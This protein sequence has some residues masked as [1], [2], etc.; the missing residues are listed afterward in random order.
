MLTNSLRKKLSDFL[1]GYE[2]PKINNENGSNG[3]KSISHSLYI[4]REAEL[5]GS[6]ENVYITD[7]PCI[8]EFFN[9]AFTASNQ[10][11]Q[12][13]IK[14]DSGDLQNGIRHPTPWDNGF[15]G[16]SPSR[17][18]SENNDGEDSIFK[19]GLFDA[20]GSKFSIFSKRYIYAPNGFQ[21]RFYS[22]VEGKIA[23]NISVVFFHD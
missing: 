18:K 10:I 21:L 5:N 4:E 12:I 22:A 2:Q 11:F 16:I 17:L 1:D 20:E 19:T 3:L 15:T 6:G 13:Q 8:I 9:I 7:K 14:D 23:A